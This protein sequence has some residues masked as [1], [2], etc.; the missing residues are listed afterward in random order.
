MQGTYHEKQNRLGFPSQLLIVAAVFLGAY[1]IV[2]WPTLARMELVWRHSETYMHAYLI[3]PISIWLIWR[4]RNTLA[5]Y[6]VKPTLL[7]ALLALPLLVLWLLAFAIDVNFVSQLAAI[8]YLQLLIWSLLGH[9][10]IRRVW[11][12]VTFL[13]FLVPFGEAA[14][15]VLQRITA[16]MVIHFLRLVDFPVFRDGLYIF[17]PSAVFEVAVACSGLNF[18][19]TSLVLSCLYSYLHYTRWYKSLAF[20]AMTLVLSIIA[21]GIR[22]FLL[23]VIGE[24]SNLTYGFGADHYYYGWLVFFIVIMLAFWLGAKFEDEEQDHKATEA[25]TNTLS[26]R[27]K[28]PTLLLLVLTASLLV[29]G[30]LSRSMNETKAPE[31]PKSLYATQS[32]VITQSSW[33]IQFFD[34]LS[35]DHW[36]TDEGIELFVA[37]YGHRQD[38]GDMITWHNTLFHTDHWSITQQKSYG[39]RLNGYSILYLT[40]TRGQQRA[41][42]YWYQIGEVKTSSRVIAKLMQLA[43]ILRGDQTPAAVKAVSV[44]SHQDIAYLEQQLRQGQQQLLAGPHE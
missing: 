28:V 37:Q 34:G 7:P 6:P 22:A 44:E 18:L 24:K 41:L 20:I 43:A 35:R 16:D 23:V 31:Q 40:N 8:I 5:L 25:T 14:N 10:M 9:R 3:L 11:F 1:L 32:S 42:L 12:P 27:Y 30:G 21:N 19:L 4:E 39:D 33:G 15:P 26:H 2:F 38:R 17:T 29:A 13:I 36:Q